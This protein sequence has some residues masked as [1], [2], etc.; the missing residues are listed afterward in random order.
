MIKSLKKK[1][2]GIL[3]AISLLLVPVMAVSANISSCPSNWK[4][5]VGDPGVVP[6]G[7]GQPGIAMAGWGPIEP[8]T[9]GGNW[10]GIAPDDCRVMWEGTDPPNESLRCATIT[11][12]CDGCAFPTYLEWRALDGQ[13]DDGYTI[14]IDG[15][16]VH[17]YVWSGNTAETWYTASQVLTGFNLP[18]SKVHVVEFCA[19]GPAWASFSTYGQGAIDWVILGTDPCGGNGPKVSLTTT[20]LEP[21]PEPCICID[22]CPSSLSFGP[23]YPGDTEEHEVPLLITNCGDVDVDV[24]VTTDPT[25]SF[26]NDNLFLEVGSSWYSLAAWGET[27]DEGDSLEIDAKVEVPDPYAATTENGTLVFWATAA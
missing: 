1:V 11:F 21:E 2:L 10:G 15:V 5:D 8:A 16:L 14:K 27:I 24:T 25:S 20:I 9:H 22:V 3:L 26:Y 7:E 17:T 6:P 13:A 4:V 19:T 18:N 12:T 23:L